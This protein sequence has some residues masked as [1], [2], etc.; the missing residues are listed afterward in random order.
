MTAP[1]TAAAGLVVGS[2]ADNSAAKMKNTMTA[3]NAMAEVK[4]Y[5]ATIPS[6]N[7]LAL[8]EISGLLWS[9]AFCSKM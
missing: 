6:A 4:A 8:I 3:T 9:E 2:A 1:I 5:A 7:W